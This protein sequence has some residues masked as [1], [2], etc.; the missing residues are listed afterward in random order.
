MNSWRE[1]T[2]LK[3]V[4]LQALFLCSPQTNLTLKFQPLGRVRKRT[5]MYER[6]VPSALMKHP[7]TRTLWPYIGKLSKTLSN[8]WGI[9]P[10]KSRDQSSW[11]ERFTSAPLQRGVSPC[12]NLAIY[13]R[14]EP[15]YWLLV[16]DA[17][18]WELAKTDFTDPLDQQS[19]WDT[20]PGEL[21]QRWLTG[22]AQSRRREVRSFC[23]E[24]FPVI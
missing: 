8:L 4:L 5:I 9:Q 24:A 18:K 22:L 21:E 1:L 15:K 13:H 19:G 12:D 20:G 16:T 6:Q 17:E 11:L 23:A 7:L 2:C 14:D 10:Q 3:K